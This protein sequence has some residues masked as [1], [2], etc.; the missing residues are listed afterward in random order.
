[1][2]ADYHVHTVYSD[3]TRSFGDYVEQ[4]GKRGLDEIGFSDHL[5]V[6]KASWS[7]DLARLPDYVREINALKDVSQVA[8]K[9]GLEVDFVPAMTDELLKTVEGFSF[10]YLIGSVHHIGDWLIDSATQIDGWRGKDVD[11]VYQQYFELVQQMAETRRFDIVGHIDVTKKFGFRP[12]NSVVDLL[13]ETVR[14]IGKSGVC[15]EI[16]TSG[17]RNPCREIY[18]SQD[19]LKMCFD[20]GVPVTLGSDAHSPEDVAAGFDQAIALLREVGYE[21]ISRFAGRSREFVG[22]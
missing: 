1:M 2:T 17:L 21:E 19:L 15:V 14:V 7:M 8:V 13:L 18:P 12:R 5:H 9:A 10:D 16:N 22:L 11:H 4:A 3:G 20:H 6:R